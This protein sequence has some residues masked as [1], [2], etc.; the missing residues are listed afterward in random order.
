MLPETGNLKREETLAAGGNATTATGAARG[1]DLRM[2]SWIDG[3]LPCFNLA[4]SSFKLPYRYAAVLSIRMSQLKEGAISYD[5][6]LHRDG[7]TL[8]ISSI[9]NAGHS[10]TRR[11]LT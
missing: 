11:Q 8:K 7:I 10:I 3:A 2:G 9:P 4:G 5:Y 1:S 6:R